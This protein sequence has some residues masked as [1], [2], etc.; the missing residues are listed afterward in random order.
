[1]LRCSLMRCMNYPRSIMA[2]CARTPLSTAVIALGSNMASGFGSPE[3]TVRAAVERLRLLSA[4]PLQVSSLWLTPP[5]DCPPGSADFVNAV[6][7]MP[8][9]AGSSA[10]QLLTILQAIESEFGRSRSTQRNAPRTLDLDM[11]S[12]G[13]EVLNLATLQLPHPRAHLRSFVLAPLAEIA[14]HFILPG[15]QETVTMLLA[16]QGRNTAMRRLNVTV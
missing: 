15:Q 4:G 10:R 8:L 13:Q 12:Y 7:M 1:M 14:P 6:V 11:I 16:R 9:P 5:L 3:Q 2:E